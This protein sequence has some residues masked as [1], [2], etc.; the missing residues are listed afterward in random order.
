VGR[1]FMLATL[2]AIAA[3]AQS[4]PGK[5][6]LTG[7]VVSGGKAIPGAT[8][9]VRSADKVLTTVT[10]DDGRFAVS[11]A[12]FGS[13]QIQVRMFGFE[14]LSRD[15]A[16]GDRTHPVELA[17][18]LSA[19]RQRPAPG[20]AT[21]AAN[22]GSGSTG[23]AQSNVTSMEA[24]A[25][26]SQSLPA[27]LSQNNDSYLVQG[28]LS[29]GLSQ[30][31]AIDF[32]TSGDE[33]AGP[34]FGGMGR[35]GRGGGRGGGGQRGANTN[36]QAFGNRNAQSNARGQIQ[37][38][39]FLNL[40][41]S[42][43]DAA[44]YS[45][46]GQALQKP[47]YAQSRFGGTL[48]G[49][50][51][52]PKILE[53]DDTFFFLNYTGTRSRNPSSQFAV[54]PTEAERTGDFSATNPLRVLA[55]YD[56]LTGQ[57]FPNKVIPSARIDPAATG[58]LQFYP[59]PNLPGGS[60]QNYQLV[61]SFPQ[62]SDTLSARVNKNLT[63]RDRLAF[64]MNWQRRDSQSVQLLGFRDEGSGSGLNFDASWT[65]NFTSRFIHTFRARYNLNKTESQPYFAYGPDISAELGINGNSRDPINYGPPNLSFTNFGGLSDG[66]PLLRR[67]HNWTFDDGV[68][69]V[70]GKHNVTAGF[71]FQRTQWNTVT[72]QNA[73]GTLY[74]SGVA[75]SGFDVN[76]FPIRNTGFD[77]ADLFLGLP[78]QSS[79]RFGGA[80][81]YPRSSQYSAYIQDEWRARGNFSIN[82]GLRY[83]YFSPFVEKYGRMANLDI[84][85]GFTAVAVVT[86]GQVGPYSGAFPS[87]LVDPDRNNF[88]PRLGIAW[89]P[90]P[91]R[92]LLIRTGYGIYYDSSVYSRVPT[93]LLSQPPFGQ[94]STYQ[95]GID[96]ILTLSYPF[97]GAPNINVTNSYAVDRHYVTPYA[98]TWNMAFQYDLGKGM[99]FEVGY[100]GTKG[101]RLIV[102]R[103][104]NR[105]DEPSY[106]TR[107]IDNAT[108]FTYDSTVG[109]SIFH[110]A[111][112]R[113][114]KRMR[115][116]VSLNALYTFSKSIDDAS[117]IGGGGSVVVQNDLDFRAERGLSS[118]D[119]RHTL[120]LNSVLTSPFGPR[121]SFLQGRGVM[122]TLLR[123]WT[124]TVGITAG[125][126]T[127]YTARVLGNASDSAGTG[128]VGS[129]RADAT[130][131]AIEGGTGQYFNLLAFRIPPGGTY[132]NAGRDT[133]PGIA[134]IGFNASFGRSFPIGENTRRRMD[135]RLEANNVLNHVNITGISTVVNAVEYGLAN[136]AGPMRS[137]NLVVR[138][139]F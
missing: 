70:K 60:T 100:L 77:L 98:Q 127:P 105:S 33:G 29:R 118:F 116:G 23:N 133:I 19:F 76:G 117:T 54:M 34:G 58:L 55:I 16:A 84:A 46:T 108:G 10:D 64:G 94:A 87:G 126:G 107:P 91:K 80:D 96:N 73:R 43:I 130:G 62:D 47:S 39:F 35:G 25:A 99:L 102:Q 138:F 65:H 75:T 110:A 72:E 109:N 63:Q 121:G 82:A 114:V 74:F 120:T 83:E 7:R 4:T 13:V 32:G 67:I 79:I 81:T 6:A 59:L 56:P 37:G 119:Q 132:G 137:L 88:A 30:P 136:Q 11:G 38:G 89:R 124:A 69:I 78:Q 51:R 31:G 129:S 90:F 68:T 66:A 104:P 26:E 44:P 15:I 14:P 45:V 49:L 92:H 20:T 71:E 134:Q 8:V 1:L 115:K 111:Q 53:T 5:E 2:L 48:G 101:T 18:S 128:A 106:P 24:Q 3:P 40:R 42:A 93:H 21:N 52:I 61:T 9:V 103:I 28:S 85:P 22:A 50:L 112:V 123:D 95:T 41:N 113:F 131:L 97:V 125:S 36:V 17:I 12:P 86:P 139:R 122:T 27:D 135:L 57:P